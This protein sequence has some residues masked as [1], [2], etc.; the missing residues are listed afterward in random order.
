[1][2]TGSTHAISGRFEVEALSVVVLQYDPITVRNMQDVNENISNICE[3]M[4]KAASGFPGF[5]LFV[6][7]EFGLQ[8]IGP[9]FKDTMLNLDGPE[10]ERLRRKCKELMVW[11]IFNAYL[12][13]HEGKKV[14]NVSFMIDD[15]GNIVQTY[16][17]MNPYVPGDTTCPG[18]HCPVADGPKGSKIALIT[19]ADGDYPEMWREAAAGGANII[20]RPTHYGVLADAGWESTN[21]AAAYCNLSYVIACGCV[22]VNYNGCSLGKSMIVNPDGNIVTQAPAGIPWLM[23]ADL[24]P[25]IVDHMRR[26]TVTN[27][28]LWSYNHR[29]AAYGEYA[30]CGIPVTGLSAYR[31]RK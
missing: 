23:K 9:W 1:M 28:F 25:A 20:V 19:C 31:E 11:G 8:G 30:G 17:K 14:C 6:S 16:R 26:E 7:P 18:E 22:D 29:G 24:Y 15:E 13:E 3:W 21:R 4:E 27:N 2:L 10:I 5:D 12:T